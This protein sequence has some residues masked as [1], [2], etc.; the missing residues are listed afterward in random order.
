MDDERADPPTPN[1]KHITAPL[2]VR[3]P[4]PNEDEE[5]RIT[6]RRLEAARARLYLLTA[7]VRLIQRREDISRGP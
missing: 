3:P 4:L 1:G 5:L 6:A 7:Q 2:T